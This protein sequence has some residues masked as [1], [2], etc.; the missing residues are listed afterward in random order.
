MGTYIAKPVPSERILFVAINYSPEVSG[1]GPY[2][3]SLANAITSYGKEVSVV[4]T[5]PHYPS[6]R[7]EAE[8]KRWRSRS[9]TAGI[10]IQ[11]L[12]HYVPRRPMK[13]NRLISEITF[14]LRAALTNWRKPQICVLLSPALLSSCI[15]LLRCKISQSRPKS[16]VWVQDLYFKGAAELDRKNSIVTSLLMFL[17][18]WL[19]SN[20]DR[21][22]VIHENFRE[23]LS[24]ELGITQSKIEVVRNWT[25]AKDISRN[26]VAKPLDETTANSKSNDL[27]LLHA[28]NMGQKQGL[29]NLVQA[30]QIADSENLPVIFLLL[31]DGSEKEKL[32]EL[33]LG[34]KRIKFIE[35]VDSVKFD[36]L[37]ST[38]DI[39]LVN[40]KAGI[41]EMALPS[42]L[43]S[44]FRAGKPIIAATDLEGNTAREVHDSGAGI[45]VQSGKPREILNSALALA[46]DREKMRDMGLRGQLYAMQE[47]SEASSV[48]KFVSILESLQ[49]KQA[50]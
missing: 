48:A 4:T 16:I 45:V 12:L 18:R 36:L 42:K 44:Y 34:V 6:W 43:T 40:E 22:V 31:G 23:I 28:G 49:T 50:T 15:V 27:V 20:A 33:A 13:L 47:L 2:V 3:G 17:E 24:T 41:K 9:R 32:Q 1:I 26:Q 39:L 46:G 14:G 30:A 38:S 7:I 8:D 10:E 37:L 19:F 35:P 29:E 25:H 11:R 21:V 5:H